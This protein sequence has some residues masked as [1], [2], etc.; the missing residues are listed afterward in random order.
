MNTKRKI[1]LASGLVAAVASSGGAFTA[2]LVDTADANSIVGAKDIVVD[3]ATLTDLKYSTVWDGTAG[4][5]GGFVVDK[6]TAVFSQDFSTKAAF[7]AHIGGTAALTASAT[8]EGT[9]PVANSTTVVFDAASQKVLA[10][11]IGTTHIVVNDSVN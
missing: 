7:S 10:K 1:L 2:A 4:T 9:T 8:D 5:A 11:A 6:V 3:G